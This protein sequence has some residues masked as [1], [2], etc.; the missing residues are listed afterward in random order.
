MGVL[1][2]FFLQSFHQ[3]VLLDSYHISQFANK[4]IFVVYK[5]F[6]GQITQFCWVPVV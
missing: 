6:Y 4:K 3:F 1:V 2:S 5:R